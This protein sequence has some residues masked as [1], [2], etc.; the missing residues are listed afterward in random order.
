MGNWTLGDIGGSEPGVL[1][2]SPSVLRL[3]LEVWTYY[4]GILK[5]GPTYGGPISE[6]SLS[7]PRFRNSEAFFHGITSGF[8]PGRLFCSLSHGVHVSA[9]YVCMCIYI[10][11]I[12]YAIL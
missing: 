4:S 10:E 5:G 8:V 12:E 7:L 2:V 1:T 11:Y 6:D 9:K 3:S